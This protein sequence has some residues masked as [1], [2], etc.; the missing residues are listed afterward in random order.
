MSPK[1][2]LEVT[3]DEEEIH[4]LIGIKYTVIV[5]D[6]ASPIITTPYST[7]IVFCEPNIPIQ[8]IGGHTPL[9]LTRQGILMHLKL[10]YMVILVFLIS[11]QNMFQMFPQISGLE[12]IYFV[13]G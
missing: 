7:I 5:A 6:T 13:K 12:N 4:L 1:T 9:S 8:D 2:N 10:F 3:D 11:P